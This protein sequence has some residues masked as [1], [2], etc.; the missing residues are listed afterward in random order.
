M[1]FSFSRILPIAGAMLAL[2]PFMAPRP[3]VA[4]TAGIS[5]PGVNVFEGAGFSRL[6]REGFFWVRSVLSIQ[7]D[8]SQGL[9]YLSAL[10]DDTSGLVK[11]D[12]GTGSTLPFPLGQATMSGDDRRLGDMALDLANGIGLVGTLDSP[13][14]IVKVS[15]GAS[16]TDAPRRVASIYL[17]AGESELR[18]A[19]FDTINGYGYFA[20]AT[21]PARLIKVDPGTG[22]N[23]PVKVA[24]LDISGTISSAQE[25]LFDET[26]GYL[27]ISSEGGVI[28]KYQVTAG[29]APPVFVGSVSTG[30]PFIRSGDIDA[31]RGYA[32]F[33]DQ[34][35]FGTLMKVRLDATPTAP[36]LVAT[37]SISGSERCFSVVVDEANGTVLVGRDE[38]VS[39]FAVGAGDAQPTF[40]A[41]TTLAA[42]E[43]E[44]F[45]SAF[46]EAEGK[47]YFMNFGAQFL[48]EPDKIIEMESGGAAL[49]AVRVGATELPWNEGNLTSAAYDASTGYGYFATTSSVDPGKI[50]KVDLKPGTDETPLRVAALEVNT[51]PAAPS[52]LGFD[53][54]RGLGYATVQGNGTAGRFIKFDPGVGDAAPTILSEFQNPSGETSWRSTAIYD[55]DNNYAYLLPWPTGV[56]NLLKVD[57]GTGSA[58]PT[59]LHTIPMPTGV[60]VITHS[61]LDEINNIGYFGTNSD[62]AT[63]IKVN[64]GAGS[65]APSIVGTLALPTLCNDTSH[66]SVDPADGYALMGTVLGTAGV[67]TSRSTTVHRILLGGPTDVPTYDQG[68][69]LAPE[70]LHLFEGFLDRTNDE[71]WFRTARSIVRIDTG[72]ASGPFVRVGQ[73]YTMPYDTIFRSV[74]TD[75]L[76]YLYAG[77]GIEPSSVI[78]YK[79]EPFSPKNNLWGTEFTIPG[80]TVAFVDEMRFYSHVAGGDYQFAIYRIDG[81]TELLWESGVIAN[82][83]TEGEVVV[84]ISSGAP[85]EL[86][87]ATGTYAVAWLTDSDI[88]AASAIERPTQINESFVYHTG[89]FQLPGNVDFDWRRNNRYAWT[90]YITYTAAPNIDTMVLS[91][92]DGLNSPDPGFTNELTIQVDLTTNGSTPI[93]DFEASES[94]P[95]G[96]FASVG[97]NPS[98]QFTFSSSVNGSKTLWVRA[99]TALGPG[100]VRSAAITYDNIRP[101]VTLTIDGITGTGPT[102]AASLTGSISGSGLK[103]GSVDFSNPAEFTVVNGSATPTGANAFS[104]TPAGDGNVVITVQPGAAVDQA[105]NTNSSAVSRTITVDRTPPSTI[106]AS[107]QAWRV[108]GSISGTYTSS[109]GSG[110]GVAST[111]LYH[112]KDNGNWTAGATFT[113]GTWSFTPSGGSPDGD[114]SFVAVS[115]DAVGNQEGPIP[116]G[117]SAVAGQITIPYNAIN[118]STFI[119]TL[120]A[121]G[122]Y[123]YPM[124]NS[125]AV[126]VT[127]ASVDAGRQFSISRRSN[128][129]A[130]ADLPDGY[131]LG[132]L[133]TQRLV[134]RNRFDAEAEIG[135]RWIG[136]NLGTL[137]P[138]ELD[139]VVVAVPDVNPGPVI[140]AADATNGA[141]GIEATIT[142]PVDDSAL[143]A[144]RYVEPGFDSLTLQ[145][146]DSLND[147]LHGWTNGTTVNAFLGA[148]GGDIPQSIEVSLDPAFASPQS[149]P[150]TLGDTQ[151]AASLAPTE[152]EQTVYL[153]AVG[154]RGPASSALSESIILDTIPPVTDISIPRG[155]F[156]TSGT[157]NFNVDPTSSLASGMRLR[158]DYR[159][160]GVVAP[161]QLLLD[162]DEATQATGT[163]TI[164]RPTEGDGLYLVRVFAADLAGNFGTIPFAGLTTDPGVYRLTFNSVDGGPLQLNVAPGSIVNFPLG[165]NDSLTIDG[166]N[167]TETESITVQRIRPLGTIPGAI[168]SAQLINE[169]L[170]ITSS[171]PLNGTVDLV[172]QFDPTAD[173]A[174]TNP[175]NTVYRLNGGTL[176]GTFAVTPSGPDNNVLTIQNVAAFSDWYAANT[177]TA[178]EAWMLLGEE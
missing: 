50:V 99:I 85:T 119:R 79:G 170:Q 140:A 172:W 9:A 101:T 77:A 150:Y 21:S 165:G 1:M 7:I 104:I 105:G 86:A 26:N 13:A 133:V 62:P 47:A 117:S 178:V 169:F 152:G 121:P 142:I 70:E 124:T 29:T 163:A 138:A 149:I 144:G 174:L 75:G 80:N 177:S 24:S 91:D 18:A 57:L 141:G 127:F 52:N 51:V 106:I 71:G 15:L 164:N 64:L 8:E 87:L 74:F 56:Q 167:L 81:G 6:D 76:G 59:I 90:Q 143:Y 145:D 25:M 49:P 159:R 156:G 84:P 68:Y 110:T 112:R 28:G 122:T 60:G 116:V 27:Y 92:R 139:R 3:S 39:K 48:D 171:N 148:R 42:G 97:A 114:Y 129:D 78:K 176:S 98:F 109:D 162:V 108:A 14:K 88:L 54:S 41:D 53:S 63:L 22:S 72:G 107:T 102:N 61:A 147:P 69:E 166:T 35:S 83:V 137:S 157:I 168:S 36:E 32:Y 10:G 37:R 158:L 20:T 154:S 113:G 155:V 93:T 38:K 136:Q 128:A 153:R 19:A 17:D 12:L 175:V 4:Q 58:T 5:T 118:D 30:R 135:L 66:L 43:D 45:F 96:G 65:A 134:F 126:E 31:T 103:S 11:V 2:V 55:F 120:D 16:R 67:N 34:I 161:W 89:S 131:G 125:T 111:R 44:L 173:A 40:I 33:V 100:P 95:T 94:G 46:N 132:D 123:L 82:T 146:Q 130:V 73:T 23:P 160:E 151:F 115:T